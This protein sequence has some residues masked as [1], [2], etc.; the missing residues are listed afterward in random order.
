M[1]ECA[2]IRPLVAAAILATAFVPSHA[3]AFVAID[4]GVIHDVGVPW[5]RSTYGP[6]EVPTRSGPENIA[7]Q[8]DGDKTVLAIGETAQ[9]HPFLVRLA[10]SGEERWRVNLSSAGIARAVGSDTLVSAATFQPYTPT[11]QRIDANG[12]SLWTIAA[13]GSEWWDLAASEDGSSFLIEDAPLTQDWKLERRDAQGELAWSV[14]LAMIPAMDTQGQSDAPRIT[15]ARDGGAFVHGRT[16]FGS[17]AVERYGA[18]GARQWTREFGGLS[19]GHGSSGL[20]EDDNGAVFLAYEVNAYP[21]LGSNVLVLK[22]TTSGALAG[23]TVLEQETMGFSGH[24]MISARG[25]GALLVTSIGAHRI[26]SNGNVAWTYA[27]DDYALG[28]L[29]QAIGERADGHIFALSSVRLSEALPIGTT[30]LRVVELDADGSALDDYTSNP[31]QQFDSATALRVEGPRVDVMMQ[32][33]GDDGI[34]RIRFVR[35]ER[36]TVF[37]DGFDALR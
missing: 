1:R 30:A 26:D 9:G 31:P 13:P 35:L 32:S 20:V 5:G 17:M 25:G 4:A 2:L 14:P 15:L 36:E 28:C 16:F 22:V 3:S 24:Q 21:A 29:P 23:T 8:N 33:I 11:L 37:A 7:W 10:P 34:E 6:V 12:V 18:D 19:F 27:A